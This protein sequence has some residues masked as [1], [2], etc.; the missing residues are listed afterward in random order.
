MSCWLERVIFVFK[1]RFVLFNPPP[2]HETMLGLRKTDAGGDLAPTKRK[3]N[4]VE[5]KPEEYDEWDG[6]KIE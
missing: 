3:K 2:G 6:F 4:N 1:S 5:E